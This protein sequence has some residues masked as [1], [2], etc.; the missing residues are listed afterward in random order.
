MRRLCATTFWA[1]LPLSWLGVGEAHGIEHFLF[2]ARAE[3]HGAGVAIDKAGAVGIPLPAT[4]L[5]GH[6]D[7]GIALGRAGAAHEKGVS[8]A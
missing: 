2:V 5:G 1:I 8:P 7:L 6:A 3:H 4:S